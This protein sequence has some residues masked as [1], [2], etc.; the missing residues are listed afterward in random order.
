MNRREEKKTVR[1]TVCVFIWCASR[2]I[3]YRKCD[4]VTT[5]IGERP[6]K[7]THKLTEQS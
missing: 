3:I 5:L 4:T 7:N 2:C 6:K 1:Q